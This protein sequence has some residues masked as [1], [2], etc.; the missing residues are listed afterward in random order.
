MR[1]QPI[2]QQRLGDQNR[3]AGVF[4]HEGQP[5]G[6]IAGVERQIGAARLEDAHEPDEH[7]GRAL[8]AQPHHD[9]GTDAERAQVMRQ[10]VGACIELRDR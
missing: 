3:R 7:R 5:L 8:D 2:E 6:R 4:Q 10:L 1:G 9:L